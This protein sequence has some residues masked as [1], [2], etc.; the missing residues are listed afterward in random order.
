MATSAEAGQETPNFETKS[1][2]S[3]TV[4]ATDDENATAELKVTVTVTNAE[5]AGV[6]SLT[7]REP[8]VDRQVVASLSDEDGNISGADWR[9]VQKRRCRYG[10]TD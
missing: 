10:W 9:M 2:Y 5:D 6:V 7:Q 4:T 8:Q 1:S 3:V